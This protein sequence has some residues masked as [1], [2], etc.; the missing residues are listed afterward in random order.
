[1][2]A[3]LVRRAGYVLEPQNRG[4]ATALRLPSL[5][6]ATNSLHQDASIP[7][8][9]PQEQRASLAT[10]PPDSRWRQ[11]ME[12]GALSRMKDSS[13][14]EREREELGKQEEGENGTYLEQRLT[15]SARVHVPSTCSTHTTV[16]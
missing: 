8:H 11:T 3:T 16:F 2:R 1:M 15:C 14:R 4:P 7:W 5:S 10:S 9:V 13:G 12:Q 6:M